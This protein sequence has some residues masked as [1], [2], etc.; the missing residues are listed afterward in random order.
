V[1]AIALLRLHGYTDEPAYREKAEQTLELLAGSAGQYGLFAATYGIAAVHFSVP[2]T[3]VIVVGEDEAGS[4]LYASAVASSRVGHAVL[5]FKFNQ[6]VQQN[7]PPSLAATIPQLPAVTQRKT[8]A[9]V[10][11]GFAC[12]PPVETPEQLLASLR[13]A[14]LAA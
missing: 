10:C 6:A 4:Q 8:V 5:K 7:L 14:N 13:T 2:P 12:K 11:S 9:V 3:Q 1:A